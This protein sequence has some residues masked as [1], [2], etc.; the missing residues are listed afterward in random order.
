M[1][2]SYLN[3]GVIMMN[4][5]LRSLYVF[6]NFILI[7]H[8]SLM[9]V[10]LE[11]AAG[12]EIVND[13]NQDIILLWNGLS[14]DRNLARGAIVGRVALPAVPVAAPLGTG[15]DYAPIGVAHPVVTILKELNTLHT[16]AKNRK[17]F[18]DV[19][20][21]EAAIINYVCGIRKFAQECVPAQFDAKILKDH[22]KK[23]N[24]GLEITQRNIDPRT[25]YP[26]LKAAFDFR[27]ADCVKSGLARLYAQAMFASMRCVHDD[28][29][30]ED[31]L[32]AS[33]VSQMDQNKIED[34]NNL[35]ETD[36]AQCAIKNEIKR[37]YLYLYRHWVDGKDI[38]VDTHGLLNDNICREIEWLIKVGLIPSGIVAPINLAKTL[39]QLAQEFFDYFSSW[40]TYF[41]KQYIP[42][43]LGG[44]SDFSVWFKFLPETLR[45][46]IEKLYL[47]RYDKRL[48]SGR[49]ENLDINDLVYLRDNGQVPYF[50]HNGMT[51]F[52]TIAEEWVEKNAQPS[53]GSYFAEKQWLIVDQNNQPASW[54]AMLPT[55]LIQDVCRYYHCAVIKHH[56]KWVDVLHLHNKN[57]C[58]DLPISYLTQYGVLPLPDNMTQQNFENGSY[59]DQALHYAN[60]F[61]ALSQAGQK[62]K[63]I[64]CFN[65]MPQKFKVKVC[66][67]YMIVTALSGSLLQ[68]K[69]VFKTLYDDANNQKDLQI[70]L[71]NALVSDDIK[72]KIVQKIRSKGILDLSNMFLSQVTA[73]DIAT[74]A[75][76]QGVQLANITQLD[77]SHNLLD[78]FP[79]DI[80]NQLPHLEL[81]NLSHN[82]LKTLSVDLFAPGANIRL[83][84]IYL[85]NNKFKEL[86]LALF[87]ELSA[88]PTLDSID[89][90]NN[91]LNADYVPYF[92]SLKLKSLNLSNNGITH[93]Q[94]TIFSH[95][96]IN[97]DAPPQTAAD[98][99]FK[100]SI[101][102]LNLSGNKLEL[103]DHTTKQALT[104]L[105]NGVIELLNLRNNKIKT[106][107]SIV[108]CQL[109]SLKHLLL[110][111]NE[112]TVIK[113]GYGGAPLP[114]MD[115]LVTL[116]VSNNQLDGIYL[117]DCA[118]FPNLT[119]LL[120]S[121]NNIQRIEEMPVGGSAL[122]CLGELES[123]FL[124]RNELKDLSAK[125]FKSLEKLKNLHLEGNKIVRFLPNTFIDLKELEELYAYANSQRFSFDDQVGIVPETIVAAGAFNGLIKL[126][127]LDLSFNCIKALDDNAL[128]GL[129]ELTHLNLGHNKLNKVSS[130]LFDSLSKLQYL[131][132]SQNRLK[133]VASQAF[134]N[135]KNLKRVFFKGNSTSGFLK[136]F[137]HRTLM[138]LERSKWLLGKGVSLDIEALNR[139]IGVA[140]I[141]RVWRALQRNKVLGIPGLGIITRKKAQVLQR[142]AE[143]VRLSDT[144]ITLSS[145]I[146]CFEEQ[147][148]CY[149]Q[150]AFDQNQ[151]K[152]K[153]EIAH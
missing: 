54:L 129:T 68:E 95:T 64:R 136:L 116:D 71:T 113:R 21:N 142:S 87:K 29:T 4:R 33:D 80:I 153:E 69:E 17:I 114:N 128:T 137:S 107:H 138:S 86:P 126:R 47:V 123:L 39:P 96:C 98:Q 3:M 18:S 121:S 147:D 111:G 27:F 132:L 90:S 60:Y 91:E 40:K 143:P 125:S 31:F 56:A 16:L 102:E 73:A 84:K 10:P 105:S 76:V 66:R 15:I 112:I 82:R 127:Y 2:V 149:R 100:N 59:D 99:S 74:I 79:T 120:L 14:Q 23:K 49:I 51:T 63:I 57:N 11:T 32:R 97:A 46:E 37:Q 103:T 7:I 44:V 12:V 119:R 6:A 131:D 110:N 140:D 53:V 45:K 62:K 106:V 8:L 133:G 34:F 58:G 115:N 101:K 19:V 139:Y 146:Q 30:I 20:R 93:F 5:I 152:V 141:A 52:L 122:S 48:V 108:E 104:S 25:V 130:V 88:N 118:W 77:L 24:Y 92:G 75:Q 78:Q 150:I 89:L 144:H 72:T 109:N 151:V 13:I 36:P 81:L 41:R 145:I 50:T 35:D 65:F 148:D 1:R 135:L 9:A 67:Q 124:D 22:P 70:T 26:Y 42:K 85:N 134:N 117:D 61:V 94:P 55:Q 43:I 38:N 28:E 83:K